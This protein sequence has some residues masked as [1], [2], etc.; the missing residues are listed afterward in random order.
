[1]AFFSPLPPARSGIADYS[2]ALLQAL[3]PL[4][5]VEVF[6]EPAPLEPA[7]FDVALYQ[8]GNNPDH[9]FV[10]EA[11]LRHPGVVVM[12]ETNLHHLLADLTIKR[13]EWDAYVEECAYNGGAAARARAE[14]ARTLQVAPDYEGVRMTRRLLESARG[15]VTHSGFAA[16]E[17]RTAGFAGPLAVI[18]HG[19]WL[20]RVD[21]APFRRKLGVEETA[22]L[23]GIFGH[24][25]PYKRIAETL[26][27]FRRLTRVAPEAKMILVGEPHPELPL[28]D[29]I[30]AMDLSG[31]VRVVG[32]APVEDFTGY[33]AACDVVVNLRFPTVGESSGTL[34][35]AFGLGKATLVSGVGSFGELPDDACVKI[36]VDAGEEDAIFEYLNL[37]ASRPEI[38]REL[39]ARARRYVERECAWPVVAGKCVEFLEAVA[40]GRAT[41]F[42]PLAAA[43]GKFMA[44]KSGQAP[45]AAPGECA[46]NVVPD[47]AA[48]GLSPASGGDAAEDIIAYLR[49]WARDG[50]SL[51]YLEN[52]RTRLAKTLAITP[53][54]TAVDRVLE[55]GAYLQITPALRSRLGYGEVRGCY[56]GA[57]GRTDVREET[58]SLGERFRCDIDHFDAERD[59]FPYPDGHFSTVLCCELIEHLAEDP[60]HLMAEANRIIKPDGYLLLTTPNLASLR[61]IDAVLLGYHPGFYPA[62]MRPAATNGESAARHNREYTPR[63]VRK[64]FE[65]AGFEIVRLET[66]EFREEPHPEFAWVRHLLERYKL[67]AGLR[68]EGIYALGR[69]R[70]AVK[71]R[72]PEWL[73][74]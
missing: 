4:A 9:A 59:P 36:P 68:G 32:F 7:R 12:H 51:Q 18:P 30:R 50:E 73:Y 55:M 53:P 69:K 13:G 10:Y 11:A 15:V 5:E 64:L 40:E 63:E 34:L 16:A 33:M 27:A 20:D 3:H 67:E 31:H 41:G 61:A 39:G 2:A 28:E 71:E 60:M 6:P 66:G 42:H 35:R 22:P 14:Q 1:M 62:Y 25:K 65:N 17:L 70:G 29:A 21:G 8:I 43:S 38:A 52:H 72:Y 45:Q 19:A 49:T 74:S 57:L 56:F 23:V 47:T 26:R 37:L 46:A 24:L 54:G 44:G 58:S 48:E